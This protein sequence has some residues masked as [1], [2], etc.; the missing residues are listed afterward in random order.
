VKREVRLLHANALDSL[1][2]SIEHFNRPWD[3]G[4]VSSVLI[5]LDHAFEQLLKAAILH[6]KGKIRRPRERQTLGFDE[7]VRKALT[8]GSV[9]FLTEEQALVLQEING[10]RD[11]A[12]HHLV[13]ISEPV[14][15]I[16]TQAGVTLFR[17]LLR[18][19]FGEELAACLPERVLP[20][21]T[22][23]ALDPVTL[24]EREVEEVKKL[25]KPGGRK[26]IQATARL[27]TLA[28]LD[29]AVKGE[30]IQPSAGEL[31]K[32]IKRVRGGL[33]WEQLFPGIA[34]I[35]ITADGHGPSISL[36][37]TKK[38]GIPIQLVKEGTEGSFVGGVKRV[39]E[40]DFYSLRLGQLSEKLALSEPKTLALIR[41]AKLQ[42]NPDHYK[43]IQIGSSKFPRYSAKALDYLAATL[44][45]VS[46]DE[47]WNAHRPR[48]KK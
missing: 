45:A 14:L 19:V 12:Y 23:P 1:I 34:S 36:R 24:F 27:K 22:T 33:T 29:G 4:R 9:K 7:C 40:L 31:R 41:H 48:K 2:L 13:G 8:D 42:E 20:L 5:L 38:E 30:R 39:N 43:L 11:A 17:D 15:Y 26:Q 35:Q 28:I 10:L 3:R 37:I 44:P 25:L 46:M 32:L 47:V 21:S 18:D 6:R 16:Q